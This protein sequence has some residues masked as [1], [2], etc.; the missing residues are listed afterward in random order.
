MEQNPSSHLFWLHFGCHDSYNFLPIERVV[1]W[2]P[3]LLTYQNWWKVKVL[4]A[5][6]YLTL[7]N[8]M[9]Y[10]PPGS[11]VHGILQQE[12]WSGL[13]FSSPGN[14]PDPEIEPGSPA[15][16]VDSLPSEPLPTSRAGIFGTFGVLGA[17]PSILVPD[18]PKFPKI[19]VLLLGSIGEMRLEF[20]EWFNS[21]RNS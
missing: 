4:V 2:P 12:Y 6:S 9:D 3:S 15:L 21:W 5:Q 17:I 16:Q 8:P 20:S 18:T 11:P 19:P 13:P 14:L 7:C 1:Y 10:N